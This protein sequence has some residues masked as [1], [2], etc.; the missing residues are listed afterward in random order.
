MS[1]LV[2]ENLSV[3]YGAIQA[4]HGISLH[5]EQGEVV[6][7]IGGN[8]AGKTTTLRAISGL[9][10]PTA[11]Q[12]RLRRRVDRR[13]R[14][15]IASCSRGLVQVPEGRGI[16]ANL[17]VEENLQMG[18]YARHDRAGDSRRITSGRSS[19]CPACASGCSK[20]PARSPAASS[21]CWRSPGHSWPSHGC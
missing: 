6:T 13:L 2:V 12:H 11:G 16:F 9:L 1:F 4:L 8:G 19:C 15:R 17:T 20:R 7:L 10:R 21:R 18:A 3:C 5:V 14:S